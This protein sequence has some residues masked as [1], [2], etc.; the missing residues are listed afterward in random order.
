L[1]ASSSTYAITNFTWNPAGGGIST[2][3]SGNS[4]FSADKESIADYAV[5]NIPANPLVPG[6]IHESGVLSATSFVNLT[7]TNAGFVPGTGTG[8]GIPG[9]T[10][11]QLY[12]TF[13]STSHFTA[14]IPN[15]AVGVFDSL[16]YMMWGDTGGKC[17]FSPS[18]ANC[19]ASGTQVELAN[20]VLGNGANQVA[21]INGIPSATVDLTFNEL[22]PGFFVN[23]GAN[24]IVTMEG[25]F[26]N[27]CGVVSGTVDP[28]T[29]VCV[30]PNPNQVTINGGGG[31]IDFTATR[32]VPE[33]GTLSILGVGLLLAGRF[34]RRRKPSA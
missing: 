34:S 2:N 33:P 20:G 16:S 4:Q 13:T 10:S 18:G 12:I 17:A 1:L 22:V 30:L 24:F 19:G 23:P 14:A 32:R 6:S 31:N 15:L 3:G 5:I 27:T 8:I 21:I 29:K 25:A 28:T 7:G 11:Y 9:A 26:T